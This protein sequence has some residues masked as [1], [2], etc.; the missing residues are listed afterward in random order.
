MVR[1]TRVADADRVDRTDRPIVRIEPQFFPHGRNAPSPFDDA[2]G[3]PGRC[4]RDAA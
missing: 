4:R 1:S 2:Q 3:D